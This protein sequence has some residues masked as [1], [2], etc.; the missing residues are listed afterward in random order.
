MT[1]TALILLASLAVLPADRLALADR[2]FNRGDYASAETE[3]LAL[4]GEP[5][6][7][8]DELDYR[9]AECA[10]AAGDAADAATRYAALAESFPDSRHA[11]SA[12][13]Q[14][15]LAASGD[16]RL[17]RLT[18]L[19]TD[20]VE[21]SVR[22]AALY[23]LGAERN[24]AALLERCAK[25]DP[26]GRYA[27]YAELRRGTILTQAGDASARRKGV[28]V[29]LGIAFGGTPLADDAL[30]L[31]ASVSYREKKYGEAGSLFRRYRK[32]FPEGRH[33]DEAK[34][35]SVWCDY[36]EGRYADAA[37]ACG[38]GKTDDLAYVKA[39]CAAQSGGDA[40]PLFRAYLDGFPEGRYRKDAALQ[41]ARLEFSAAVAANDAAK[42]VEAAKRAAADGTVADALRLAWTYEKAGRAAEAE[43]E[44]ARIVR[45]SPKTEA[46]AKALYAQAM[47]AA[48][49]GDW[50]RAEL[51]LAEA[52]ATGR[53]D[54]EQRTNALY[55]RG[56]AAV[57]IGHGTEGADFLREALNGG[58][59]GL[60]EAREAR[61]AVADEDLKSGRVEAAKAAYAG[62]VRDGACARMSAAKVREVG[63][64]LGGE[65]AETCA[66]ALTAQPSP[67]WR[68]AG[69]EMLGRREEAREAY[70]AAIA[71]YRKAMAEPAKTEAAAAA[72]LALGKLEVRAGE[73]DAAEATLKAAVSLNAGRP[74]A[75]GEA[76]LAL[77][78]NARA[79]GDAQGARGYATVVTTL[80]ADPKLVAEAEKILKEV[81]E[82]K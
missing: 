5:S 13:L 59:L 62:L 30:F 49:A 50:T 23:H 35:L 65:A 27:P 42:A 37:A 2:L 47:S 43:A 52:L 11:A 70:T 61:L 25:A 15:A 19:D 60:D 36:T 79:K 81:S 28:E 10:R 38:E 55:W 56:V 78:Q 17:R 4:V 31:A 73:H 40:A 48:R 29:L 1:A 12:R 51:R 18:A 39:C 14:I 32:M 69:W 66:K 21:T 71:A 24:D 44:Y 9:L 57:R 80:F 75:R 22:A 45:D 6:I 53:L 58:T 34:T 33:A 74:A 68:Q 77:A 46:A 41:L 20:R 72:A 16:E 26:K 64:L 63:E 3:Y 54:A 8:A 76:Y 67:E 82:V 7:A